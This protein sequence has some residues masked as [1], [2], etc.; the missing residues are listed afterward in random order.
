MGAPDICEMGAPDIYKVENL[1][2]PTGHFLLHNYVQGYRQRIAVF[3]DA[4]R[5]EYGEAHTFTRLWQ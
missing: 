2:R 1:Q 3:G 5:K 4:I